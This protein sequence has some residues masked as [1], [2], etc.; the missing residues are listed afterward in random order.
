MRTG[1]VVTYHPILPGTDRRRKHALPK[2]L[3]EQRAQP[4][5]PQHASWV[6]S[7]F[8]KDSVLEGTNFGTPVSG[9]PTILPESSA[10]FFE[11]GLWYLRVA[12][13]A[14]CLWHTNCR[15]PPFTLPSI[16]TVIVFPSAESVKRVT[17]TT[18]GEFDSG[19]AADGESGP[20]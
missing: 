6:L 20:L 8:Q 3:A 4:L 12:N 15:V 11:C 16:E 5:I 2:T 10:C 7:T 1:Q 17:S 14:Y 9:L 13:P 19:G 18:F